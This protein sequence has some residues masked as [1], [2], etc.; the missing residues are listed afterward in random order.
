MLF[1][2]F[3][4]MLFNAFHCF[5]NAFQCFF[6]AF[7]CAPRVMSMWWPSGSTW[8]GGTGHRCVFAAFHCDLQCFFNALSMVFNAFS[9]LFNAFSMLFQCFSFLF[10]C[11]SML[12]QCFSMSPAGAQAWPPTPMGVATDTGWRAAWP[13][14][15]VNQYMLSLALGGAHPRGEPH[16]H[17]GTSI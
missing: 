15:P 17:H 8:N 9:M 13:P 2:C 7:P 4:S 1:Q 10:Q 5:L 16:P 3:F 11:F 12:L 6:N 14:T